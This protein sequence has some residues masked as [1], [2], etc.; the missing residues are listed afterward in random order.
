MLHRTVDSAMQSLIKRRFSVPISKVIPGPNARGFRCHR[1]NLSLSIYAHGRGVY[2][3]LETSETERITDLMQFYG[4]QKWGFVIYRCTYGDNDAWDR[5]MTHMNAR[6][7]A[8]VRDFYGDEDL[9]QRLDWSV[10]Q[11]VSLE[12]ASKD[13][14]R[15]RFRRWVAT[16]GRAESS[17]GDE[18]YQLSSLLWEN[19]R[20][21]YCVHVDAAS[22]ASVLAGPP[23]TEPDMKNVSYVNLIRA[24]E[25]WDAERD[26]NDFEHPEQSDEAEKEIRNDE[27]EPELE[28][29]TMYDVGYMKVSVDGLVPSV[30]EL[31]VNDRMW[32]VSYVRPNVGVFRN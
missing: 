11:D 2:Y 17:R 23:P 10:Q 1:P 26:P 30:Y 4:L 15:T 12:G 32:D 27:G 8:V 24:D 3:N 19:P 6:K 25:A 28:G 21:K 7:D 29:S 14:V 20:F 31:L 9:A 22:M 13:E 16:N 18:E 5:F